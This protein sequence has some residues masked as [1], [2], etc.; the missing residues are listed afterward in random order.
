MC[1][2]VFPSFKHSE[3]IFE[4]KRKLK[5]W[6]TLT[7]LAFQVDKVNLMKLFIVYTW[8]QHLLFVSTNEKLSFKGN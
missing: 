3:S 8:L 1:R 7:F 6:L 5:N 2:M 4:L